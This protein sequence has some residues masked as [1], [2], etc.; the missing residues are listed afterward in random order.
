[1]GLCIVFVQCLNYLV[2]VYPKIASS[3]FG[4]NSFVRSSFAAG[5]PLFGPTMYHNLGVTWITS[6]LAVISLFM[7]PIPLLFYR[8]GHTIRS[9]SKNI[10]N[11]SWL[12]L[13]WRVS[14]CCFQVATMKT[15]LINGFC[16]IHELWDFKSSFGCSWKIPMV[17]TEFNAYCY[18]ILYEAWSFL[19]AYLLRTDIHASCMSNLSNFSFDNITFWHTDP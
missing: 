15:I 10:V 11:T 13:L 9:W 7:I 17:R 5:F 3:A 2:D 14:M 4:A 12:A 16:L 8:Y 1:M 6:I 19:L 18:K